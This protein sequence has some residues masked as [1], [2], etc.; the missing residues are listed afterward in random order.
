MN[1][2]GRDF[3]RF[4]N[5][6]RTY[7]RAQSASNPEELR[8]IVLVGDSSRF[9]LC[10]ESNFGKSL[11]MH[12]WSFESGIEEVRYQSQFLCHSP[13]TVNYLHTCHC[14][15]EPRFL[16]DALRGWSAPASQTFA[17]SGSDPTPLCSVDISTSTPGQGLL[18]EYHTSFSSAFRRWWRYRQRSPFLLAIPV[19]AARQKGAAVSSIVARRFNVRPV[20]T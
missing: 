8:L 5:F 6:L 9:K 16:L 20:S 18:R 2:G 7:T 15:L 3:C 11:I 13:R 17:A 10:Y 1:Y 4:G 12:F 14:Y 19:V